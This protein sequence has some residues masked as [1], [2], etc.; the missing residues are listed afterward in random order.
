MQGIF[1]SFRGIPVVFYL[2]REMNKRTNNKLNTEVNSSNTLNKTDSN[3]KEKRQGWGQLNP[4]LIYKKTKTIFISICRESKVLK[5][6]IEC[7]L[8]N[9]GVFL[10]SILVFEYGLLPGLKSLLSIVFGQNSGTGSTIWSW[11]Q[12]ALSLLFGMI[13]ILPLFILSKVVN[14]LWFQVNLISLITYQ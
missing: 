14:S 9:G 4:F 12:P 2:D 13:W 7:C 8:L 6:V 1:D 11:M 10:A 5:R 3:N